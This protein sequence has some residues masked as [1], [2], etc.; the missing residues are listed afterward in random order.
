MK[1]KYSNISVQISNEEGNAFVI[2]G[3]YYVP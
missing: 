2:F 3:K 1:V